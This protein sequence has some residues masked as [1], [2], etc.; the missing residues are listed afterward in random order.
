MVFARYSCPCIPVS[1]HRNH[2]FQ[3]LQSLTEQITLLYQGNLFFHGGPEREE[4]AHFIPTHA[5]FLTQP[6]VALIQ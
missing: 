2:G 6:F 3:G 5:S 4:L 1:G